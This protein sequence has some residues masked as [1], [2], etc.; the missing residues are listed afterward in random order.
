MPALPQPAE[1]TV[2]VLPE[3]LYETVKPRIG[4]RPA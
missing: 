4:H 2:S 3:D 1:D